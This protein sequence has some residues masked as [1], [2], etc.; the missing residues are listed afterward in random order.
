MIFVDLN[1]VQSDFKKISGGKRMDI[2]EYIDVVQSK[3]GDLS[4]SRTYIFLPE[5]EENAQFIQ[6]LNY[7]PYCQTITGRLQEKQIRLNGCIHGSDGGELNVT[8]ATYTT[9]CDKG[10][11]VNLVVE[12]LKN[13]YRDNFDTA[14]IISRDADFSSAVMTV[15]E[16]GKTVELV[17]FD[18]DTVSA[19]E[20]SVCV[21]NIVKIEEADYEYFIK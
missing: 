5:T 17:L 8:G 16:L 20:L 6:A 21:D 4:F 1:N 18:N 2:K 3:Y 10:T 13:A 11:D 7:I 12:M 9:K 15:K 19:K 14:I